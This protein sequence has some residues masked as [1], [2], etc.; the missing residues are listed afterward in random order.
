M[1]SQ[2]AAIIS[3]IIV[4]IILFILSRREE[5]NQEK[6]NEARKRLYETGIMVEGEVILKRSYFETIYEVFFAVKA[7]QRQVS[8]KFIAGDEHE[9]SGLDYA[10][11]EL[12]I[13]FANAGHNIKV[14][15]DPNDPTNNLIYTN[16]EYQSLIKSTQLRAYS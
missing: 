1:M 13:L 8:Y 7:F 4:L 11:Y 6:V 5:R 15:Y 3:F 12:K 16:K 9:Y 2:D 14:I 10:R